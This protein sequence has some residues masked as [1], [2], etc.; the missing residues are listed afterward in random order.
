MILP[1]VL[2]PDTTA[3]ARN[4][5]RQGHLWHTITCQL[6]RPYQSDSDAP[7]RDRRL[8]PLHLPLRGNCHSQPITWFINE[9]S[10]FRKFP[11][12]S[13]LEYLEGKTPATGHRRESHSQVQSRPCDTCPQEC[14]FLNHK[15]WVLKV[16]GKL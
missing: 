6:P 5:L 9:P 1:I 14:L 2:I 4:L 15:V 7:C 12:I 13:E 10:Q 16:R 11:P 8:L 3:L